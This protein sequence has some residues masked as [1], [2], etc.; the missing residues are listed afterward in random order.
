MGMEKKQNNLYVDFIDSI[1][2]SIV[3]IRY[4]LFTLTTISNNVNLNTLVNF[5]YRSN[6]QSV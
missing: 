6:Y 1:I 4:N 2:G 3:S 5:T